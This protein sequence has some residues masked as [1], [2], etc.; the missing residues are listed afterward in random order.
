M[1]EGSIKYESTYS[2]SYDPGIFFVPGT[3]LKMAQPNVNSIFTV[4]GALGQATSLLQKAK[5]AVSSL[6]GGELSFDAA[7]VTDF[8]TNAAVNAAQEVLKNSA[9]SEVS[10]AAQED[11]ENGAPNE[12]SSATTF[13]SQFN[14]QQLAS[15]SAFNSIAGVIDSPQSEIAAVSDEGSQA[16]GSLSS[17]TGAALASVTKGAAGAIGGAVAGAVAGAVGGVAGGLAGGLAGGIASKAVSSLA[18]SLG[19]QAAKL[20]GGKL[21]DATTWK[22]V[23]GA[24]FNPS[25]APF[26]NL[27][28]GGVIPPIGQVLKDQ[29]G[30]TVYG[31]AISVP[32]ISVP[33]LGQVP[34]P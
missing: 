5:A 1:S 24:S 28:L 26:L 21:P 27:S 13:L 9:P 12:V 18:G 10:S 31:Q 29:I 19:P 3:G 8:A 33:L 17:V 23:F 32:K 34:F 2:L 11:L 20:A 7:A 15:I 30:G 4:S 14:P 6:S 22:T 25:L 16:L